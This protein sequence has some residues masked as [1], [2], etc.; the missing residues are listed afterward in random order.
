MSGPDLNV[1]RRVIV[2]IVRAAAVEAP[3]VLRVARGGRWS[4]WFGRPAIRVRLVDG[5]VEA[6]VWLIARPGQALVPLAADVR[7]AVGAAI[8]RVLGLDARD[9]TVIVDGV[10]T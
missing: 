3:G 4:G 1:A 6:R 5:A 10:G 8:E 2:E 9:V 7:A